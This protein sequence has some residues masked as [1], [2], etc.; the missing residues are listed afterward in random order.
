[1][2]VELLKGS[3][4]ILAIFCEHSEYVDLFGWF[5]EIK[6]DFWVFPLHLDDFQMSLR[7]PNYPEPTLGAAHGDCLEH[8]SLLKA[9]LA[10]VF[11][12]LAVNAVHDDFVSVVAN[13]E[14]VVLV[15]YD[16]ESLFS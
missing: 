5:F 2:S 1:M 4:F 15:E 3:D 16:V 9:E 10:E 6:A 12:E 11:L 8:F 7:K 13:D 14:P